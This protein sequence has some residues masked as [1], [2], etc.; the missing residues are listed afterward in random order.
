MNTSEIDVT[1]MTHAD[2]TIIK[3]RAKKELRHHWWFG[4]SM[5]LI[6]IAAGICIKLSVQGSAEL[7]DSLWVIILQSFILAIFAMSLNIGY[8]T[9]S[10]QFNN[11]KNYIANNSPLDG[12]LAGFQNKYLL[13]NF[14]TAALRLILVNF[15]TLM[16][17]IPGIIKRYSY[18]L[19]P[20]ILKDS[21][22]KDNDGTVSP[23]KIIRQST[24]MMAGNKKNMFVFDLSFLGWYLLSIL[25]FGI[26]FVF[27]IPYHQ[28][29]M[30][31]YYR[32]IKKHYLKEQAQD[33]DI[34]KSDEPL[35]SEPFVPEHTSDNVQKLDEKSNTQPKK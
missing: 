24:D 23:Q 14:T 28:I 20:Y 5:A 11:R 22:D 12:A 25:T 21:L 1:R 4:V 10:S 6:Y 26:G 15:W 3:N 18:C 27:L 7:R 29:A 2:R 31:E 34:P 35:S 33:F 19:S 17:I 8:Y 32:E 30:A 9:W 16:L 13:F